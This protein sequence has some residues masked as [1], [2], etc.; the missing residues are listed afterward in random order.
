MA[1]HLD[2]CGCGDSLCYAVLY[3]VWMAGVLHPQHRLLPLLL[4]LGW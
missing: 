1:P 2:R 4:V 3:D